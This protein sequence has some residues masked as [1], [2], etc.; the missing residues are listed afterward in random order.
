MFLQ[1][2]VEESARA[3]QIA[4]EQFR[5]GTADFNRV[6]TNQAQLVA[7]QDQLA[8]VRG[9]TALYLIQVYKALGGGWE[10]FCDGGGIP[11]VADS[12]LPIEQLPAMPGQ[13]VG[14]F[15]TPK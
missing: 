2:S 3:V 5:G 6:Y 13:P 10:Y 7:A 4:Q 15:A 1:R 12:V 9:N 8:A 11:W 14:E